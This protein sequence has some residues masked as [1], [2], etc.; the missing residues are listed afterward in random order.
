MRAMRLAVGSKFQGHSLVGDGEGDAL[1][2]VSGGR[3]SFGLLSPQAQDVEE[4]AP[5]SPW[6]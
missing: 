4:G 5:G 6:H 3:L 1:Q 2:G